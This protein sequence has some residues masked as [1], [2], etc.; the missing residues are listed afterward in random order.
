MG[1]FNKKEK[2]SGERISEE[3]KVIE[4][5]S[6]E[7]TKSPHGY[8][9]VTEDKK[10]NPILK[11]IPYK[12]VYPNGIMELSNGMFSK[13]YRIPEMNFKTAHEDK[14][15][16]AASDWSAFI[17]SFDEDVNIEVSLC[18]ETIDINKFQ[19]QVLLGMKADGLNKYREE[20][21][22]MLLSRMTGAKNNLQTIPY[23]TIAIPAEDIEHAY[24]R[25]VTI[26]Q[27]VSENITHITKLP[28]EE[29]T[30]IERL[31]LL[32]KIYNQDEVYPLY[33]K[34]MING[35]EVESFSLE[36]CEKQGI[37]TK[38]VIAP[39]CMYFKTNH[40]EIGS[41]LS[42][43]YILNNYPTW[44]KGTFLTSFA[45]IPT[46]MLISIHF[47]IMETQAAITQIKRN[48]MNI[49]DKLIKTQKHALQNMV[50]PALLSPELNESREE[51]NGLMDLVT[52]EN[53]KLLTG[54]LVITL[55]AENE[56]KLKTYE[57]E[58]KAIA[59][60]NLAS[61]KCLDQ[62]QEDGFNMSL[63]I[64]YNCG[65][66]QRLLTSETVASIVPF[67]VKEVRHS[68]GMYYGI[69]PLSHNLILY[70]KLSEVNPN[71]CILGMPGM[72]KSFTAKREMLNVILNTEDEIYIIDPEREYKV[73]VEAFGGTSI[74]IANGTKNYI[75]PFDLNIQD[76][77]ED[78]GD[79]VKKKMSFIE[80]ISE[81]MIGNRY[82][83]SPIEKSIIDRSVMNIYEPYIEH[84]KY[85]G[86][87]IDVEQAPTIEDFYNDLCKQPQVE[88]ANLALS[89]ERYVTGAFDIF[90][91]HS[92][93][94]IDNR[95]TV[96]DIKDIGPGLKELGL[97]I[98]LD[99]IWNKMISNMEHGKRTW[100][101]IDEFYLMMQKESSAAYIAQ[102]WKRARKWR[103]IPCAITQNVED[104]LKSE[105]ARTIINNCSCNI[106]L[107]QAP[108]NKQQLSKMLDISPVEQKY[109][110]TAK[111]G[112]G[113]LKTGDDIIPFDDTFPKNTELYKIMTTKPDE[114]ILG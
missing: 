110:S 54:T 108:L 11:S 88:A 63:P 94:Q 40:I 77:G 45:E 98:C 85:S 66:R 69:N 18:N 78:D 27:T 49:S 12:F 32:N 57:T 6:E 64:G 96:Y 103:G 72:G 36:N 4:K 105:E 3:K 56:D 82:G 42:K 79:P 43:T 76:S 111:P 19:E 47:N 33:E 34:R 75:N 51:A 55:F 37:T 62:Q 14:Q 99:S 112:M 53:G 70:D 97:Q 114:R 95:L 101:Y 104:M 102:I 109:I 2:K 39:S 17:C 60:K 48:R 44:I 30:M 59:N 58:L 38:D 61:V 31:E 41:Q 13:T 26:D 25:F 21:N 113:L 28:A 67:N 93:I 46:N 50:D 81:I 24:E 91:H 65:L 10:E 71:V 15:W 7:K 8:N 20:Y 52:K 83:L 84:L 5:D 87:S 86:L 106:L 89:L 16:T 23:I 29:L 35:H 22:N 68:Q 73:F 90:S 80:T 107:G 100:I 74:K 92:N 9:I 1:L